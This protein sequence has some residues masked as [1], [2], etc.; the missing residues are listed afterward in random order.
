MLSQA[1][2][3]ER[4]YTRL[5]DS[6]D[7]ASAAESLREIGDCVR[8]R[9]PSVIDDYDDRELVLAEDGRTL[10][11][12]FGWEPQFHGDWFKHRLH[13]VSPIARMCRATTEPFA[14]HAQSIAEEVSRMQPSTCWHLTPKKGVHAGVTVPLHGPNGRTGSVTWLAREPGVDAPSILRTHGKV[15]RLAAYVFIDLLHATECNVPRVRMAADLLPVDLGLSDRE[16]ECLRFAALGHP[17]GEIGALLHRSPVTARFHVDNAVRK[18]G[19]RNRTH[20]VAKAV[21]LGLIDVS[22]D[23]N[24]E[25]A[26]AL[27]SRS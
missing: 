18:L 17:D 27:G 2:R 9:Y 26:V 22:R 13:R 5:T 4:A 12:I 24:S 20:A 8:M 23:S 25:S 3:I 1:V 16:L 6:R 11:S 15:L 7:R 19:A 10:A 21:Q 14:W